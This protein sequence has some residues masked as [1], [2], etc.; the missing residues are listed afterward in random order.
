M[1]SEPGAGIDPV[2]FGPFQAG[3]ATLCAVVAMLDGFDTQSIAYVA[4]RIAE[5]WGLPASAFG[6]I[7][8]AG[9]LGLTIGAFVLSSAADRFGRK[10]IILLS[11]AIFGIFALLSRSRADDGRTAGPADPDRDRPGRG[12]AQ[13]H[14]PDQRVRPRTLQGD[15]GD[16]DVLRLSAGLDGRR[17]RHRPR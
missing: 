16:G 15:A 10:I 8:G 5:D 6:P 11:V 9:L 4:P 2:Q 7:F 12:H 13:H 1:Q 14:R 17:P 3:V